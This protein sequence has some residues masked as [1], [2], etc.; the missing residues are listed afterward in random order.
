MPRRAELPTTD[1][2]R[3]DRGYKISHMEAVA[4]VQCDLSEPGITRRRHGTGFSYSGPDGKK[5]T[6]AGLIDHLKSLA[7]PPAWKNVWICPDAHGHIQATGTDEAGRTQYIYHQKWREQQDQMKFDHIL[8]VGDALPAARTRVT[9]LLRKEDGH[10]DK[11][12]GIAFRLLDLAALRVG[13]EGYAELHGSYGL[14]TMLVKHVEVTHTTVRLHFPSKS[15]QTVD[16]QI[17]NKGLASAVKPL[18]QRPGTHPALVWQQQGEWQPLTS[19]MVN[20][21][22]RNITGVEMS[23]KDFRTWHATII[24]ARALARGAT[25]QEAVEEVAEHLQNTPSI[26]KNSYIDPRVFERFEQ[27]HTIKAGTYREAERNLRALVGTG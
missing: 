8:D 18:L 27:G 17:T 4:L 24:A 20:E 23:A 15:G 14:T 26:A 22:L 12:L 11:T 13:N 19:T 7:V 9:R 5:I 16:A 21:F 2:I 10:R 25:P 6:D 3:N 1:L